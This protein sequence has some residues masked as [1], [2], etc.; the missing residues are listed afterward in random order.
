MAVSIIGEAGPSASLQALLVSALSNPA[1]TAG[2]NVAI[3][4]RQLEETEGQIAAARRFCNGSARDYITLI[5]ST[6][7]NF[8]AVRRS[9]R[10]ASDVELGAENRATVTVPPRVGIGPEAS[11]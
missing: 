10:P 9:F 5:Q 1:R 7:A 11:D 8:N 6:P 3:L 4:Q 2:E